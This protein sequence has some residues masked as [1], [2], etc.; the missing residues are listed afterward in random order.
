MFEDFFVRALLAGL[1]LALIAGP[2][3]SVIVWRRMAYFGDTMAHS[4]LLG[5]VLA[6]ILNIS[7]VA[8][9]FAIAITISLLLVYLHR[10]NALP[11]DSLLGILSHSALA[12]GLVL[13]ALIPPPGFD[14]TGLLFGDILAV[15]LHDIFLIFTAGLIGLVTLGLIWR[16][17]VAATV[18]AEMASAEGLEP[19]RAQLVFIILLAGIIA[20]AMKV[21]GII[22]ITSLLIIPAATARQFANSPEQMAARSIAAGAFAVTAGLLASL[23][24]DTPSGPSITAAA[25]CLFAISLI[26]PKRHNRW[27]QG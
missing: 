18:S 19:H 4:A 16:T 11:A 24:F 17:L 14:L 6:Y 15:S 9:V 22:L 12:A 1:G 10:R 5:V 27:E 26:F 23:Q 21:V 20:V 2:A 7:L 8:G 3:G 25:F 13:L